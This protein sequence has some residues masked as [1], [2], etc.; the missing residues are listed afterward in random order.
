MAT[1]CCQDLESGLTFGVGSSKSEV[2]SAQGTPTLFS[3]NDFGY[4]NSHVYFKDN[5]V[6]GWKD[7]GAVPLHVPQ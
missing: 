5:R 2:I 3:D 1:R 6:I 7:S 4:G